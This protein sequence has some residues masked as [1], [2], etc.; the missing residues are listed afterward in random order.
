MPVALISDIHGNE[1]ALVAVLAELA[2]RGVEQGVVLG[3]TAY[4]GRQPAEVLDRLAELG[5]PVVIGNADMVLVLEPD[6]QEE[7][8]S[9]AQLEKRARDV[10]QLEAR[11]FE[12][13][14]SWPLTVDVELEGGRTLRA[15]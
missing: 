7:E 9:N 10:S 12:Q 3:D 4:G 6:A 1:P 2:R 8:L 14:R 5:W 15:F 13:M 11:H